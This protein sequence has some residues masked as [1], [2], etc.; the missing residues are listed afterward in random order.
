MSMNAP[1]PAATRPDAALATNGL[2]DERSIP[3][4]LALLEGSLSVVDLDQ[5]SDW[6]AL[7]AFLPLRAGLFEFDRPIEA[8][9]VHLPQRVANGLRLRL[10]GDLDG[11]SD[12]ADAV[13]AAEARG[14]AAKG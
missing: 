8:E 6:R 9:N 12:R 1:V 13:I 3:A 7:A 10:A 2:R 14:K 11:F 5:I 4:A